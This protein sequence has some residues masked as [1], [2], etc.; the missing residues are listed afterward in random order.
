[1]SGKVLDIWNEP[2]ARLIGA[3]GHHAYFTQNA[4]ARERIDLFCGRIMR[5]GIV[6]FM[7]EEYPRLA[8]AT[9]DRADAKAVIV[10]V[11]NATPCLVDGNAHLLSLV[12]CRPDLTLAELVRLTRRIDFLRVW[13]DGWEPG[14]R[15]ENPYDTY[16]PP[17]TDVRH[18]PGARD[19]VN[20]FVRPP[21]RVKVIPSTIAFDS[22]LFSAADR[23]Q[24][25]GETARV[26]RQTKG[27]IPRV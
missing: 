19:G 14:S 3:V 12:M 27:E 22:V 2:C 5:D 1:M 4:G 8:A 9:P 25:I 24:P 10:N 21:A 13:H 15:Q 26:L 17:D 23:G 7:G 16:I 20:G 18:V 6:A 11:I